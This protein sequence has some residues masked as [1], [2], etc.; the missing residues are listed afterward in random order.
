MPKKYLPHY[1]VEWNQWNCC[2]D[3]RSRDRLAKPRGKKNSRWADHD[4][5]RGTVPCLEKTRPRSRIFSGRGGG[6]SVFHFENAF[7]CDPVDVTRR[8]HSFDSSRGFAAAAAVLSLSPFIVLLLQRLLF[9][10]CIEF[11]SIIPSPR[12]FPHELPLSFP[13]IAWKS[14]SFSLK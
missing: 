8:T 10:Q 14:V 2:F 1:S 4:G 9:Q 3:K 12:L 13:V 11:R 7:R 6:S 5:L